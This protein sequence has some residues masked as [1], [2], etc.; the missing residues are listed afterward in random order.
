MIQVTEII[1]S[2]WRSQQAEKNN[3]S[4]WNRLIL[5]AFFKNNLVKPIDKSINIPMYVIDKMNLIMLFA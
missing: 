4:A 2:Q 1:Y 3:Y 5:I